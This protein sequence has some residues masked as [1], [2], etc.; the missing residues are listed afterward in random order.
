MNIAQPLQLYAFLLCLVITLL[1]VYSYQ[2]PRRA[3]VPDFS[4]LSAGLDRKSAFFAYLKPMIRQANGEIAR[5]RRAL[6]RL[7]ACDRDLS[8]KQQRWLHQ[9]AENYRLD[10]SESTDCSLVSELLLRVDIIPESLVL[11][12]AAKESGWGTARFAVA[13]NNY[14]GQ[15]CWD[16]GC[17]MMPAAREP[18]MRHEVAEFESAEESLISYLYNLNSHAD[19][20]TLRAYRAELRREGKRLTGIQLAER[21]SKYSERRRDYIDELQSLIRF[22]K[23]DR[24]TEDDQ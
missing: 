17:G 14:F 4:E 18:G 1:L 2:T 10:A 24:Q 12:Q 19:Y 6:K 22:N 11:A 7:G 16:E 23:L 13:G 8:A 5:D 15:R 21:L 9:L 3:T 20:T